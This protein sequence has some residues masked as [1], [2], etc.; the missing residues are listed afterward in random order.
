MNAAVMLSFSSFLQCVCVC[1][2]VLSS[3]SFFSVK[4]CHRSATT[5]S[6]PTY[7]EKEGAGN[8][9]VGLG[10]GKVH[11]IVDQCGGPVLFPT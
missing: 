6:N 7:H 4:A 3:L 10:R 2:F 1:F 8:R 11:L 9:G 5:M